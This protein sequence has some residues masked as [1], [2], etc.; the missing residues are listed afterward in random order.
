M[1][2]SSR[3]ACSLAPAYF[4]HWRSKAMIS[5]SR[6]LSPAAAPACSCS[7]ATF[8]SDPS[9]PRACR[10]TI[11]SESHACHSARSKSGGSLRRQR[12]V[13]TIC[14][15]RPRPCREKPSGHRVEDRRDV[16]LGGARVDDG[17]AREG[18]AGVRGGHDE[19]EL[20]GAQAVGPLL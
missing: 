18:L 3:M 9:S 5:R 7:C 19:R 11:R 1:S 14:T 12:T 13:G 2:N 20:V 8:T 10:A 6:S 4:H 16:V 17:E 15:K